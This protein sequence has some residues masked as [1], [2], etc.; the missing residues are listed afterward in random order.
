MQVKVLGLNDTILL[1]IL[2]PVV[3]NV[4]APKLKTKLLK[5]A[6]ITDTKIVIRGKV[7]RRSVVSRDLQMEY[8]IFSE[9]PDFY[10]S[11]NSESEFIIISIAFRNFLSL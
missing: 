3:L 9:F 2:L 10:I 11:E 1:E 5:I 7:V 6:C 8:I 4:Q